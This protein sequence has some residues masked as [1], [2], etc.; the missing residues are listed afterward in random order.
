M[1]SSIQGDGG[2]SDV[3]REQWLRDLAQV[4]DDEP[5]FFCRLGELIAARSAQPT[6]TGK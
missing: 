6:V 4:R 1:K 5:C 3:Q 2:L